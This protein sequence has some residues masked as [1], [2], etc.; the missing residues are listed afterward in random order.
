MSIVVWERE[1]VIQE[2]K[3][4]GVMIHGINGGERAFSIL[5]RCQKKVFSLE[6][7]YIFCFCCYFMT[8][9]HILV[10]QGFFAFLLSCVMR[11]LLVSFCFI[12]RKSRRRV[13]SWLNCKDNILEQESCWVKTPQ[14]ICRRRILLYFHTSAYRKKMCRTFFFNC[15]DLKFYTKCLTVLNKM[16]YQIAPGHCLH[17]HAP[18]ISLTNILT[19]YFFFMACVHIL[20]FQGFFACLCDTLFAALFLFHFKEVKS[21]G[22][23][24]GDLWG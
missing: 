2:A 22:E 13:R 21:T 15:F 17:M 16:C 9:V 10:Y 14:S 24:A 11:Y 23:L 3:P 6:E 1:C 20:I 18:K 4:Y 12:S 7:I 19:R 5:K 8:C